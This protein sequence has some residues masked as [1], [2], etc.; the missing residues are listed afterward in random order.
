M[1]VIGSKRMFVAGL[2]IT[3]ISTILFGFLNF[4]PSGRIF[5]WASIV[6]R[7]AE[8]FGDACFVTSSFAISV[9]TFP[10]RISTV[11][12]IMET[13]A[14]KFFVIFTHVDFIFRPW[15]HAWSVHWSHSL[16]LRR[17]ST[18]ILLSWNSFAC[19]HNCVGVSGRRS[20]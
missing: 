12:G 4:I 1:A 11:V 20:R 17:F 6:V 18:S 10:G 5:F 19:C 9:V 8:A 16:R 7:C 13:F 2:L 15:V 14:G 3:G